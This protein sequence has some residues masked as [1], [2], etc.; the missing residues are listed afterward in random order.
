MKWI[1]LITGIIFFSSC[2][3][4][5][6]EAELDKRTNDLMHREQEL[7]LKEQ[8]LQLKEEQLNNREK[9]LDSTTRIVNDSLFLEHQK[10]PGTWLVE[11]Q[12][13]ETNCPGSAVGDTKNEL[14][15]LKFQN[16]MV[17]VSAIANKQAAWVYTGTFIGNMLRLS[18]PRDTLE[19]SAK[20]VVRLQQTKEKEMIGEREIIQPTGCRILYSIRLKKQ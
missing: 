3:L 17:I 10:L 16:D 12:C 5:Q 8:S 2:G 7:F 9:L 18:V 4:R 1:F 19:N 20:I 11:M 15:D 14:W 13:T 6:R